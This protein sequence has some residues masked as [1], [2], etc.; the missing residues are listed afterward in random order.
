MKEIKIV[1]PDGVDEILT[2]TCIGTEVRKDDSPRN[3]MTSV[4]N[5]TFDITEHDGET[6]EINQNGATKWRAGEKDQAALDNELKNAR[7]IPCSERMPEAE[8][9]VLVC[10][11]HRTVYIADWN[12]EAW[13]YENDM[14]DYVGC[15][16][17]H[18][19]W[20]PLPEPP[21]GM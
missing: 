2:I 14:G 7:W 3:I 5:R 13:E 18:T 12:G 17:K 9:P 1:I 20:M 10:S 19:H 16:F 11:E 4:F 15:D 6:L 21:E 8:V